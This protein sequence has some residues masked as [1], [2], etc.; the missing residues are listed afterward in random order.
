M[1]QAGGL[2]SKR[3]DNAPKTGARII[4]W[5]ILDV[6]ERCHGRECDACELKEDCNGI[7]KE[8]CDGFVPID[9]VIAMKRR[10]SKETWESEM[11]C[12]YPSLRDC[13]FG[14]F[15]PEIHVLEQPPLFG[16]RDVWLGVGFGYQAR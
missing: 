7:A 4:K 16:D 11:L 3:V 15:N 9:D 2:M 12:K 6:R 13:V 14:S 8:K 5:C 1:H 10:V